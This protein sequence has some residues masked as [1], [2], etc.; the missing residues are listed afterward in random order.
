MCCEL[1]YDRGGCGSAV[2]GGG[3]RS[4][5]MHNSTVTGQVE[6]EVG[7]QTFFVGNHVTGRLEVESADQGSIIGNTVGSLDL[8]QNGVVVIAAN[9][10]NGTAKYGSNGWCGTGCSVIL[11]GT[12]GICVGHGGV[13]GED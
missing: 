5:A 13:D 8:D 7:H 12:Q 1:F 4:F 2:Y 10:V 6:N 11:R 3:R 9:T